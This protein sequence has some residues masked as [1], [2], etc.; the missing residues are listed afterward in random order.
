MEQKFKEELFSS[1]YNDYR[2]KIY[3]LCYAF[4]YLKDDVDDLFQE[5]IVNIWN[6]LD[7]FRGDSD[8]GTW[9]YRI[10]VNTAL[11]HNRKFRNY[12]NI[13]NNFF[14]VNEIQG[15]DNQDVADARLDNLRKAVSQLQ[16]HD[17]VIISLLLE[18]LSYEQIADAAGITPNYVG[19]KVN[20]IKKQLK[21]LMK[22]E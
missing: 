11:F 1:I 3:R 2:Q 15:H 19:V 12:S 8:I 7:R 6:S 17:R 14:L 10:A 18:G 22:D 21:E 16:K 13:K 4:I 9:I 20:R 5:I